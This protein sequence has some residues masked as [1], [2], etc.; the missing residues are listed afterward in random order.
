MRNFHF[1]SG[2]YIMFVD[3]Q[4]YREIS[5]AIIIAYARDVF[6]YILFGENI[7]SLYSII[8]LHDVYY[9]LFIVY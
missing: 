8:F 3:V 5:P 4:N 2:L 6:L 1:Q 7:D 9:L